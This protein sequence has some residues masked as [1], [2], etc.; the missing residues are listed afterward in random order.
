LAMVLWKQGQSSLKME[1]WHK[2]GAMRS[3]EI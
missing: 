1:K 3:S 2:T